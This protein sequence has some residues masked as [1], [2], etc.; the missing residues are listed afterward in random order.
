MKR[1]CTLILAAG[2]GV[3]MKSARPKVMHEILGLPMVYYPVSISRDIGGDVIAV[4]GHGKEYTMP[5]LEGLGAR[6]VVQDPPMGTGD[7]VRVARDMLVEMKADDVLI[8]PGDMPLIQ[9]ESI[10]GLISAYRKTNADMA[11]LTSVM[12]NP[13]GYGRVI[14]DSNGYVF[15]IV[16]ESDASPQQRQVKEINTGVYI[17]SKDFMLDSVFKLQ[18]GNAKGEFYLTDIVKMASNVASSRVVD[19]EEANGVNSRLQLAHA[20]EVLRSRINRSLMERGVTMYGPEVTWVGPLVSISSDTEIWPGTHILGHSVIGRNVKIMP[21]AWIK[22]ST[23]GDGSVIGNNSIIES[24]SIK[25]GSSIAPS[26]H[27]V[28]LEGA[29]DR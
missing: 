9:K 28:G 2:K 29:L 1:L 13:T 18:A 22:D 5:Y 16:E 26:S 17:A 12:D 3:R 7:A 15:E 23:I 19:C 27:V 20:S 24:A 14:R 25:Q 8:I 11:V 21:N 4:V 10:D 6:C